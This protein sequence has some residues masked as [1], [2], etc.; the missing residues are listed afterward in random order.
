MAHISVGI[1]SSHVPAIGQ[2]NDLQ[3]LAIETQCTQRIHRYARLN[4][5]GQFDMWAG[6][7]TEDG[8]FAR[9]SEPD[10]HI[11]GRGAILASLKARPPRTT[12]HLMTSVEAIVDSSTRARAHSSVLLFIGE[13]AILPATIKATLLGTFDDVLQKVG[14]EWSF[15]QRLGALQMKS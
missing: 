2:L 12:R 10:I 6:L 3:R 1:A 7:Y 8:V 4:D 14:G 15:A 9:P 13:G 5:A 11:R